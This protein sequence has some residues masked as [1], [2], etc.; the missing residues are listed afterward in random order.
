M[1]EKQSCN[2]IKWLINMKK[3]LKNDKEERMDLKSKS[4]VLNIVY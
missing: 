3:I 4:L 1:T 2:S